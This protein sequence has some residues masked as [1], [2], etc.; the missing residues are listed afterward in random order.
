VGREDERA[1]G[2]PDILMGIDAQLDGRYT[3]ANV[4][5]WPFRYV[6][7]RE[8]LREGLRLGG[9]PAM[10]PEDNPIPLTMDGATTVSRDEARELFER[11]IALIDVRAMS[12]RNIGYLPGSS[13]LNLMDDNAFNRANLAKIVDPDQEVLFHCEGM[14]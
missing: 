8:R 1:E 9:L 6:R 14:R 7:D 5:I 2:D 3:L 13:A 4:D 12:D 10:G 11:G